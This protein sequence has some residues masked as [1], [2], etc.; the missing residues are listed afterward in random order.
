MPDSVLGGKM[1]WEVT[2]ACW[3]GHRSLSGYQQAGGPSR[4]WLGL[5]AAALVNNS[6]SRNL[7]GSL[8]KQPCWSW[9]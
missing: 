5:V 2:F 7:V 1:L 4:E 9:Q 6:K 8:S 3:E